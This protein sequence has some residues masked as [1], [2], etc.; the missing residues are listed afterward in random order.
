MTGR[1]LLELDL[2]GGVALRVTS[3]SDITELEI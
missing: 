2:M 3:A 1:E